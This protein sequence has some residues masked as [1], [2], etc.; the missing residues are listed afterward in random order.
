VLFKLASIF[1]N[2][3]VIRKNYMFLYEPYGC[4]LK[5]PAIHYLL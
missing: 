4:V 5:H 2:W 1:K 3:L